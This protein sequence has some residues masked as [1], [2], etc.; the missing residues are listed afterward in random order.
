MELNNFLQIAIK[1]TK[2]AGEILL[3]H[4]GKNNNIEFKS[5]NSPVTIADTQSEEKIK[6]IILS[7]Y[8]SHS[9][10]GEETGSTDNNSEYL[11]VVDPL[12]G[13][14]NFSNNIPYFC[15][16]ICLL[17]SK[18]PLVAV[19]YDPIHKELFTACKG[20]GAYLNNKK[21]ILSEI[22]LPKTH[23]VSLVYTR[24]KEQKLQVNEIFAKL[25]PPQYR[26]RNMGAAALELSY[27]A[28]GKLQGI[29]INGNNPWDVCGGILLIK[30][31]GGL[32]TDFNAQN[33]NFESKNIVAGHPKIH[34]KIQSIV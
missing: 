25:I 20:Q 24:S 22:K 23:Y 21:I 12:D 34:S 6:N 10:L 31:A 26:M 19:V 3:Q 29:I 18:V 33:W 27:V 15:I 30:E 17:Q 1:A 5:D 11:W 16:S 28:S 13:T 14:S 4:F 9:I 2:E 7:N 32:I 8:P